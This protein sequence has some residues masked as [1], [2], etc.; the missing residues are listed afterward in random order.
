[1]KSGLNFPDLNNGGANKSYYKSFLFEYMLKKGIGNEKRFIK[2]N[3]FS[4]SIRIPSDGITKKY[5]RALLGISEGIL[6]RDRERNGEIKY[7]NISDNEIERFQSPILFKIINNTMFIIPEE[8]N[9]N[10]FDSKFTFNFNGTDKTIAVPSKIEFDIY[11]FI[12]EFAD[13]LNNLIVSPANNI[14]NRKITS[15][16]SSTFIQV[17]P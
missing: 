9:S 3:F 12:Y 5:V 16:K 4:S 15:A 1:M 17:K 6:F 2:E 8:I 13:H 14:F 11:N 7:K 10:I